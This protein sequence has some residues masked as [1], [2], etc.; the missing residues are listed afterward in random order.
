MVLN[1]KN[2]TPCIRS[3]CKL[4]YEVKN[5]TLDSTSQTVMSRYPQTLRF[6]HSQNAAGTQK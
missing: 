2:T 5:M 6:S 3:K 4:K 1:K